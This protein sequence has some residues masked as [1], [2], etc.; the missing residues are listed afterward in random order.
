MSPHR[1]SAGGLRCACKMPQSGA[2]TFIKTRRDLKLSGL[3]NYLPSR[4]GFVQ[5]DI[6]T[7]LKHFRFPCNP[8]ASCN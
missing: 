6:A 7:A 3:R 5:L 4:G 2:A 8:L 1:F